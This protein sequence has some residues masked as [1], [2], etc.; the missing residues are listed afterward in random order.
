MAREELQRR[1]EELNMSVSEAKGYGELLAGVDAHIQSLY[2][3]LERTFPTIQFA[4]FLIHGTL[5]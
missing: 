5:L 1:L 2:D 3:L 4:H